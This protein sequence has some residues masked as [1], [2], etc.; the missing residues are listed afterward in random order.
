MK[1]G[2]EAVLFDLDGCLIDSAPDLAGALNRLR[3]EHGL[4]SLPYD[5]LRPLVG[6]GARGM[7]GAGFGLAPEDEGFPALRD[8]FLALY[9][10]GLLN[11]TVVFPGVSRLLTRLTALD[12]PWGVVTNK[13]TRFAAPILAGLGLSQVARVVVCGDTTP[14][15]KPHPQPLLSAAAF[16]GVAPERVVYVGDDLRDAQ[17]ALA[18]GMRPVAAAW[19]YLG[20]GAPIGAWGAEFVAESPVDLLKWLELD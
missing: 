12:C 16:V 11:A 3:A 15:A 4:P 2:V 8:R 1:S 5:E 18:A 9:E 6:S 10:S 19:G 14:F 20:Q 7:I 17:A 13:A